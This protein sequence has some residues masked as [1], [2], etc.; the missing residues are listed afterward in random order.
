MTNPGGRR[1]E[2]E[3]GGGWRRKEG[4]EGGEG[5]GITTNPLWSFVS[6]SKPL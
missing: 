5:W 2:E 1:A 6:L 3:G 4:G